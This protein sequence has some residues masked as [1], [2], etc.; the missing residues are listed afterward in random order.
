[1]CVNVDKYFT[2]RGTGKDNQVK[3][4]IYYIIYIKLFIIK[5]FYY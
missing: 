4:K 2:V 3:I 5:I 1:M